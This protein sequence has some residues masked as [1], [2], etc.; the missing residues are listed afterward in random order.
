MEFLYFFRSFKSEIE[1]TIFTVTAYFSPY[2]G[3]LF[4]TLEVEINMHGCE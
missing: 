3:V 2:S 4:I 1:E